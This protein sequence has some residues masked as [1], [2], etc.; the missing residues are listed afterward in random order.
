MRGIVAIG[1]LVL[2]GGCAQISDLLSF[3]DKADDQPVVAQTAAPVTP[4][5]PDDSFCRNVALADASD[6]GFDLAT[7]KRIATQSYEQCHSVYAR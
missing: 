6:K 3:D 1:F 4:P 7:Q 5:P 2:L